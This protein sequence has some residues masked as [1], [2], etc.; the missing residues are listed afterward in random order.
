MVDHSGVWV[1]IMEFRQYPKDGSCDLHFS[2]EE[3]KII[4]QNK[5]IHFSPESLR[6]FGN[7]L[8]K[9]VM[10]FNQNFNED[11]KN[12]VTNGDESIDLSDDAS[13]K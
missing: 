11:V 3:I 10:D 13:N 12:M 9:M 5:K 4:I 1:K 7:A 2:D 6:H 8:V